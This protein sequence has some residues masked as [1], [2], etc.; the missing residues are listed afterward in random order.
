MTLL[1]RLQGHERTIAVATIQLQLRVIQRDGQFGIRL[2]LQGPLQQIVAVFI[3]T[4]LVGCTGSAEVIQKR[5]ALGFGRAM[6]MTLSAGPATF[7]KIHLTL[8][9]RDLY[10][11]A[12]IA[13]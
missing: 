9:D 13:S 10:T 11:T 3:A 8:F 1:H 6:Q 12:A 2:T 7:G 4:L 5:L